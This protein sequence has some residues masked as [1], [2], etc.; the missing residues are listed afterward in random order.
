MR[1]LILATALLA[2]AAVPAAAR[3]LLLVGNK[4]EDTLGIYDLADGKQLAKVPTGTQPHEIAVMGD[5]TQAAVVSYGGTSID[6]VDLDPLGKVATIELSPNKRPHGLL[7]MPKSERLIATTEGSSSVAIVEPD[8]KITS[9]ATGQQ[10][11]H[12]AALLGEERAFIANIGSGT[13]SVLDLVKNAKLRDLTVGGKPEGVAVAGGKVFVGDL[14]A[15]RITVFDAGTYEKLAELAIDGNAIR[16][17]ASPDGKTV[18]TSNVNKGSVTLIDAATHAVLRSFPISGDPQAA[19]V[20]LI[21][22]GDGK[23][24]Y[25]AETARN[26]VAEIDADSGKVLRRI[27]VGKNGDGLAVTRVP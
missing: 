15:P 5:G 14:T 6:I 23:R 26:Q 21:W 2:T 27:D 19:Q 8:G 11:S 9:I 25:A 22:S 10:G 18:A 3:D 17:I 20:T 1:R 13:V 16:V 7:W 12:M 4:G 24:L